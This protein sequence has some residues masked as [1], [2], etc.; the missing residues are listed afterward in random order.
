[1]PEAGQ[2]NIHLEF[3]EHGGGS[4]VELYAAHGSHPGFD[5][6]VFRLVGRHRPRRA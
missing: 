3:F 4:E 2:W 1:V 5:G 6:G